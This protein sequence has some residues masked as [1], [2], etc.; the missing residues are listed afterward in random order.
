MCKWNAV[1][2]RLVAVVLLLVGLVV[3]PSVP[4]V[5]DGASGEGQTETAGESGILAQAID[6]LV[7]LFT[8]SLSTGSSSAESDS[9]AGFDPS[10]H[11]PQ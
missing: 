4:A 7:E 3:I 11:R 6:W 5:A 2:R 1:C 9:G 8:G 10:G